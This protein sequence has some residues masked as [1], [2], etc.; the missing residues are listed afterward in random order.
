MKFL[1]CLLVLSTNANANANNR[2]WKN[3]L[4]LK[5]QYFSKMDFYNPKIAKEIP[6]FERSLLESSD[7]ILEKPIAERSKDEAQILAYT[8][9]YILNA[10]L[11]F[12]T[13][14][15]SLDWLEASQKFTSSDDPNEIHLAR[16][17][18]VAKLLEASVETDS[19]ARLTPYWLSATKFSLSIL[20]GVEPEREQIDLMIKQTYANAFGFYN[21]YITLK[22]LNMNKHI[23]YSSPELEK[24]LETSAE[25]MLKVKLSRGPGTKKEV[26]EGSKTAPHVT[27][28]SLVL[29][30]EYYA[31]KYATTP[32]HENELKAKFAKSAKR[33]LLFAKIPFITGFQRYAWS[34]LNDFRQVKRYVKKIR[35]NLRDGTELAPLNLNTTQR[36]MSCSACHSK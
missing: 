34:R 32:H 15:L 8:A 7:L 10:K 26:R 12:L 30:A 33:A 11:G 20:E 9:L 19:E 23:N 27:E 25:K 35:K 18:H 28:G 17:R 1:L 21:T 6:A 16:H 5:K 13:E 3:F 2:L 31:N 14:N 36:L 24:A 29:L 4:E 22:E